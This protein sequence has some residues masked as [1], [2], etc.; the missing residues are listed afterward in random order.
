MKDC[1]CR[2]GIKIDL[3]GPRVPES[4]AVSGRFVDNEISTKGKDEVS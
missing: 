1:V 4:G 2:I 3:C